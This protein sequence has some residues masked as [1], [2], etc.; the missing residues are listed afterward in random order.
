MHEKE[1]VW[2]IMTFVSSAVDYIAIKSLFVDIFKILEQ[3]IGL[4]R[5]YGYFIQILLHAK[6]RYLRDI[7]PPSH[8]TQKFNCSQK[9]CDNRVSWLNRK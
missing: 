6:G 4:K 3:N 9:Y 8:P 2:G 5:P 1:N 7:N